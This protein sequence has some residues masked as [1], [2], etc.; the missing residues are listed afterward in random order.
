MKRLGMNTV[1]LNMEEIVALGLNRVEFV[2]GR[3]KEYESMLDDVINGIYEAEVMN[4]PY[5]IHLPLYL[6]DWYNEDYLSAF[7][8]DPKEEKR[9]LSFDFLESNLEHLKRFQPEYYIIHFPG[10]YKFNQDSGEFNGRLDCTLKRLDEM[11]KKFEIKLLLEYF[12]SN[13][14]FYKIDEWI[15]NVGK[16]DNLGILC[17]TGHLYFSSIMHGFDF[18]QGLIKISQHAAAFHL[19]TTKG[20]NAYSENPAYQKYHHIVMHT[21]QDEVDG[22]AFNVKKTM[23]IIMKYDRPMIIE[24]SEN[25]GGRSYFIEGIQSVVKLF[26]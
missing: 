4:L 19:W 5:S 2:L 15:E 10:V 6:F 9:N 22:F 21:D 16:Y 14:M 24:A 1:H 23:D 26:Y 18:Y 3:G 11:A 13:F 25:Y 8:L 12:G 17:D 7:Y 20:K